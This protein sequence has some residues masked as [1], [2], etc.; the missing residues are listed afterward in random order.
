MDYVMIFGMVIFIFLFI[1]LGFILIISI[2]SLFIKKENYNFLA[3]V[4]IIIPCYNE[5]DNII[6]TLESIKLQKYPLSKIEVIVV[7][8]GSTDHT[9]K[10][11][12]KNRGKLNLRVLKLKHQGKSS[13]MNHACKLA[14]GDFI[15]TIDAD[16]CMK[17]DSLK[18]IIAPFK[19]KKVGATSGSMN[20][21][22]TDSLMRIFQRIEY[23]YNNLIRRSFSKVF[24]T[25][26]WFYGAFACY[27]TK[28]LRNVGFF[29]KDTMTEDMDSSMMIC[30]K[31]Y[32]V[33]NAY[34]AIAFTNVPKSVSDLVRQ[35]MRWWIGGLQVVFKHKKQFSKKSSAAVNFFF[36]NQYWWSFYALVLFPILVYQVLYWLPFNLESFSNTFWYLFR[37][38]SLSGP[39]YVIYMIP[40]WGIS[41]Y[42][43]FGVMSGI[44][45]A[46]L[47]IWSIIVFKD[48][49]DFKTL[50]ALFFYF[51]YTLI[52]NSI[53]VISLIRIL[54][55]KTSY[56]IQ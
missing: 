17:D 26:I 38:F 8:D 54:F 18:K 41:F 42:G 25:S 4:S 43:I 14:K 39:L 44:I 53:I 31:G 51:P 11:V 34:D 29:S 20:V 10:V 2:I 55:L 52:L 5:Q 33:V 1:Y 30:K 7:D 45:S 6:K 9:L 12:N 46:I 40:E 13:A 19:D 49:F 35:R 23:H 3:K 47:I 16:T 50:F 24:N 37:W 28:V 15:L 48:K 27:R 32:K 22:H 56:F 36:I 21:F